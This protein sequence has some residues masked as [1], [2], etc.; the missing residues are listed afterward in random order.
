VNVDTSKVESPMIDLRRERFYADPYKPE[1][2]SLVL[3]IGSALFDHDK[4]DPINK[5]SDNI[6]SDL[7]GC[8]KPELF[9]IQLRLL[10]LF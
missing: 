6:N 3:L 10:A 9:M 1:L 4:A 7:Y 8:I 2:A 5:T